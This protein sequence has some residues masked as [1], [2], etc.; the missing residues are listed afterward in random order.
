MVVVAFGT[1]WTL[2]SDILWNHVVKQLNASAKVSA[3]LCL[4]QPR[5]RSE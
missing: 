2:D 5:A 4:S 3:L 1:L